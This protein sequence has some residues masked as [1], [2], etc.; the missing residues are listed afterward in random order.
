MASD[1]GGLVYPP[2]SRNITPLGIPQK[3]DNIATKDLGGFPS[4]TQDPYY[5]YTSLLL[6]GDGSNGS[7]TITDSSKYS[8][9]L[10]SFGTI[11]NSISSYLFGGSSIALDGST[12]YATTPH[13][14]ELSMDSSDM[15]IECFFSLGVAPVNNAF[16]A[17]KSGKSAVSSANYS[18]YINTSRQVG[19]F[20]SQTG[21]PGTTVVSLVTNTSL[22][23]G[24]FYHIAWVKYQT[25]YYVFIGG[26]LSAS[27]SSSTTP[28]DTRAASLFI[29][30]EDSQPNGIPNGYLEDFRVTKGVARYTA[31]FIPPVRAFPDF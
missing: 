27:G 30:W 23:T 15:T 10:T 25:N 14:P 3:N 1:M 28:L 17:S 29:G 7:S 24:I 5:S 9:T 19:F 8:R 21:A 22:Q 31:D 12:S 2:R 13:A 4:N 11:K 18:I 6:H 16:I 26:R 20:V